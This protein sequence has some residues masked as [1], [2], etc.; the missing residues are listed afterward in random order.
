MPVESI[1]EDRVVLF[2]ELWTLSSSTTPK[3]QFTVTELPTLTSRLADALS[4]VDPATISS[5]KVT[6]LVQHA[7]STVVEKLA[8]TVPVKMSS[9]N[10]WQPKR[11]GSR[12]GG[13]SQEQL[14]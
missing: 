8:I 13:S 3:I 5:I 6:R 7:G 2:V 1:S 9:S 11:S 4:Y 10:A 14:I 12:Y